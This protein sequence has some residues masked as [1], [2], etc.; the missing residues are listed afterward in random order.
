MAAHAPPSSAH[1]L[2]DYDPLLSQPEWQDAPEIVRVT[3]QSM[4]EVIQAQGEALRACEQ[5]VETLQR[6]QLAQQA[7]HGELSAALARKE[8]ETSEMC[9][10]FD[11]L[12]SI[13]RANAA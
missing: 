7:A 4:H 3:F 5:K 2:I 9:E 10:A 6:A 1:L 13:S 8:K 11:E 12:A